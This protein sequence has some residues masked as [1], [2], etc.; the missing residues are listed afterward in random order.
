MR[1]R[2][3]LTL[4]DGRDATILEARVSD[5]RRLLALLPDDAAKL[6]L[7]ALVRAR[8]PDL[9]AILGDGLELPAGESLDDLPLSEIETLIAAWWEMHRA[10]FLRALVALGYAPA[11]SATSTAPA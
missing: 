6:D 1:T 7:L 10:F 8:L 2:R 3:T 5:V 11:P 9:L 4:S